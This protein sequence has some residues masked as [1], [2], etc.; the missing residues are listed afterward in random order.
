MLT[1]NRRGRRAFASWLPALLLLALAGGGCS[2]GGD[3]TDFGDNDPSIVVAIG[4]SITFGNH[5]NGID[6]CDEMYREIHGFCPRLEGLTGKTVINQGEC[7]EK[8]AGGLDRIGDVLAAYRPGVILIDYSP[9]DVFEGSNAVIGNLR[10]MIAIARENKTVPIL[11][12]L[13]PAVGEHEGWMP[14]IKDL[15]TKILALCEEEDVP[16]ADHFRAF[17]NDASYQEMPYSLLDTDGLHP[18][19]AGYELMAET[20]REQLMRQY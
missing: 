6:S 7:G 18:N 5:D 2:G 19:S 20:W 12:T 1:C 11:G 3:S 15:N 14:F 4:D 16:C 17:V 13:V 9:N 8:S 10:E